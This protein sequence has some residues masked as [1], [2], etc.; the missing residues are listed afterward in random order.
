MGFAAM[1]GTLAVL[2]WGIWH[3]TQRPLGHKTGREPQ[4]MRTPAFYALAS[5]GYFGLCY[6]LWRP[7]RLTL[8]L[9][10][11]VLALLLGTFLYF[12]G[13]ALVLAG[14]L[15]LGRM[16]NVSSSFGAQLYAD[17]QLVTHGPFAYVRHPMYL[18]ILL[19]GLGGLFLYRTW[20]FVFI[21]AH[22]PG[23]IVRARREEQAL[24][25]EFGEQWANYCRD[26]PAWLPRYEW[27]PFTSGMYKANSV[28]GRPL[29][30]SS[31]SEA[32]CR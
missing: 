32:G 31:Q 10:A 24:A 1:S 17:Q 19:V 30:V 25:A 28:S 6:W 12:A 13:L 16:Y 5:V 21:M 14:R 4:M 3:G 9:P 2:L 7:L 8:S 26:V 22:W 18:G 27:F 20:T 15:T 29:V 23:L 11:R